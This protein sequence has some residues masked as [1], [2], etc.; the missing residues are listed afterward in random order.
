MIGEIQS[1]EGVWI[2]A[3]FNADKILKALGE[4]ATA[5]NVAE[6]FAKQ[7]DDVLEDMFP[8]VKQTVAQNAEYARLL[9][10]APDDA[11][12]YLSTHPSAATEIPR[13]QQ[14]IDTAHYYSSHQFIYNAF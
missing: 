13:A 10:E 9:D 1:V 4:G 12:R 6:V 11:A 14:L 3:I 2:F 7:L 5:E 8:N